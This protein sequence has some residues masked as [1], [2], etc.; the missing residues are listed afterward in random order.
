[1]TKKI[2]AAIPL[3]AILLI[4][5]SGCANTQQGAIGGGLLGAG[6]GA[7]IGGALGDPGLGAAIGGAVGTMAGAA[8]GA[9]NQRRFIE[10]HRAKWDLLPISW[11]NTPGELSEVQGRLCYVTADDYIVWRENEQRWRTDD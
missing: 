10:T 11:K 1:M 5:P 7:I 4:L 9:E 8:A 2:F 3:L 6:I